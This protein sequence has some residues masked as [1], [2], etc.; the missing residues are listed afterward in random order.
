MG[1]RIFGGGKSKSRRFVVGREEGANEGR[2][3]RLSLSVFLLFQLL[4]HPP[5]T[6]V[7]VEQRRVGAVQHGP[8]RRDD[9]HGHARPVLG[10]DKDLRALELCRRVKVALEGGLAEERGG[11]R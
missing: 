1:N 8:A 4:S 2:E 10:G 3:T 9:E 6:S 11:L 5:L 7:A